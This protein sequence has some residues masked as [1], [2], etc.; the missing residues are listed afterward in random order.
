MK[1]ARFRGAQ[2][3][4]HMGLKDEAC[5]DILDA[6][7]YD[8]NNEELKRKL[9]KVEHLCTQSMEKEPPQDA[10]VSKLECNHLS[11][12]NTDDINNIKNPIRVWA[13]PWRANRVVE[14]SKAGSRKI[15]S[16]FYM[17]LIE[18]SLRAK[19]NP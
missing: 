13:V 14:I 19:V 15:H 11:L 6:I 10:E 7:R 9:H 1:K 18:Q 5:H 2:A 4:F 17:I 12:P 3:L 16:I 8:P